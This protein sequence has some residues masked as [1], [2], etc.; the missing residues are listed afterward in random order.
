MH[1]HTNTH[2]RPQ[3]NVFM[4]MSVALRNMSVAMWPGFDTQGLAWF[5]DMTK[6]AVELGTYA[7][8]YGAAGALLPLAVFG[9]YV[10]TL[11]YTAVCE[12][13]LSTYLCLRRPG[14]CCRAAAGA[15]RLPVP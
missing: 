15:S 4:S 10:R 6:P 3:F 5:I 8:G 12:S 1:T 13:P 7:T 14:A 11:E 2:S 9:A